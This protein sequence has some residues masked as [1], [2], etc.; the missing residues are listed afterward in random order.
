MT[1]GPGCEVQ[2]SNSV[3]MKIPF[4]LSICV[5]PSLALT[6]VPA[7]CRQGEWY[8]DY[9][10]ATGGY[11][12]DTLPYGAR[13]PLYGAPS[14]D[15]GAPPFDRDG[16]PE[17]VPGPDRPPPARYSDPAR[18]AGDRH[19][20]IP[21]ETAPDPLVGTGAPDSLL[22]WNGG[23]SAAAYTPGGLPRSAL[24]GYRFRGDDSTAYGNRGPAPWQNGFRFRPL[25]AQEQAR[26]QSETGWRPLDPP[27]SR[28]RPPRSRG[29]PEEEAYGFQSDDW[30]RRNYGDNP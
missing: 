26:R 25:T 5:L 20:A 16:G 1:F 27:R 17:G 22:P 6:A 4:L 18:T 23:D 2:P 11:G 3:V 19:Y 28:G 14:I 8:P 10:P 30:F 15:H 9:S 29:F 21:P 13:P 7:L 12:G 24:R